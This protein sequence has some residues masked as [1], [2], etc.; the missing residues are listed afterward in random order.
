MVSAARRAGIACKQ[1]CAKEGKTL[2]RKTDKRQR[3]ILGA[4]IRELQRKLQCKLVAGQA[5]VACTRRPA[6]RAVDRLCETR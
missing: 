1:T 4:V 6:D 5:A 2:R 3:T